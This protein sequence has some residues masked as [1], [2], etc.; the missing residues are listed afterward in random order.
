MRGF[1]PANSAVCF[2]FLPSFTP[3]VCVFVFIFGLQHVAA[4]VDRKCKQNSFFRLLALHIFVHIRRHF[5]TFGASRRWSRRIHLAQV[6][7]AQQW[8]LTMHL[9]LVHIESEGKMEI[10]EKNIIQRDRED[11]TH[12]AENDV[13]FT[14]ILSLESAMP[15]CKWQPVKIKKDKT[16]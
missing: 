9:A 4:S 6:D 13:V 5:V 1:E 12:T 7:F 11:E 8:F 3:K 15:K 14:N 16:F 10:E 2:C